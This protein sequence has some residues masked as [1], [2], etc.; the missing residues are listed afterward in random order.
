MTFSSLEI[1]KVHGAQSGEY[2]GWEAVHST[3]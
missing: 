3:I 1:K 2:G